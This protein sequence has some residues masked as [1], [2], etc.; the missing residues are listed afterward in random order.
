MNGANIGI[1][2]EFNLF[3]NDPRNT[4]DLWL[5]GVLNAI[6]F[7]AGGLLYVPKPTLDCNCPPSLTFSRAPFVSDPLQEHLLG[8]RGAIAVACVLSIAATVG[9]SFSTS[10]AQIIGCRIITGLTLAAKASSAPLLTAEG[11]KPVVTFFM[12][13]HF[14]GLNTILESLHSDNT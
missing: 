3:K 4:G 5:F 2:A 13:L 9:Q 1:T 7:L 6:P 14:P 11:R 12:F 10:I 8:R